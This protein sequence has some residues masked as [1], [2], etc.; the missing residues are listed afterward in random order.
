MADPFIGKIVG[1]QRLVGPKAPGEICNVVIDHR[2]ELPYWEGQSY[3]VLP[4]GIDPKKNKARARTHA[5]E[6]AR[7][8]ACNLRLLVLTAPQIAAA[9]WRPLVLDR[10]YALRRR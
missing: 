4:P 6:H 9:L 7:V 10:V 2:G 1:V 5:R 3:G 8:H